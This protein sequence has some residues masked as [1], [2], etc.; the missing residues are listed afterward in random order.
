[1]TKTKHRRNIAISILILLGVGIAVWV[2][3][4]LRHRAH[5][6][7]GTREMLTA[8]S[9][10][11]EVLRLTSVEGTRVV[12][13]NY[14]SK[15]GTKAFGVGTYRYRITF[16]I[17]SLKSYRSGDS[18][19]IIR[20]PEEDIRI[21][22]DEEEGFRVLDVWAT[23]FLGGFFGTTL[24]TAEEN[25]MKEMATNRLRQFL[26]NDG[27]VERARASAVETIGEMFVLSVSQGRVV[28]LPPLP[29][30]VTNEPVLRDYS[31][32]PIRLPDEMQ[33]DRP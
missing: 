6:D 26:E 28:V 4:G 32:E 3:V 33:T 16:D 20:L 21:L 29:P 30:G 22:E 25:N 24:S 11:R 14:T 27:T 8:I 10:V 9:S 12:P 2:V 13:V 18:L 1:M 17:D 7:D 23:G 5:K 19:L 31:A 15:S